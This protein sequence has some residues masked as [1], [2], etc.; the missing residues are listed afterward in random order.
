MGWWHRSHS[1]KGTWGSVAPWQAEYALI[2]NI[3][4]GSVGVALD[5]KQTY[6]VFQSYT[7][8]VYFVK[9]TI[10]SWKNTGVKEAMTKDS[11]RSAEDS[12]NKAPWAAPSGGE[13]RG[14]EMNEKAKKLEQKNWVLVYNQTRI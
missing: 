13:N 8:Y 10:F 6:F 1:M 3:Y 14:Q 12:V 7:F 9:A 4:I 11:V 5:M 2:R